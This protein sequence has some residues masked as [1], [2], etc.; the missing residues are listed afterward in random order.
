MLFEGF[1]YFVESLIAT[2][3]MAVPGLIVARLAGAFLQ[4]DR[5][6]GRCHP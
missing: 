3:L 6:Y 1:N 5:I 4:R 2:L